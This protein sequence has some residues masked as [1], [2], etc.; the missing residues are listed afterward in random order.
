MKMIKT[1][2]ALVASVVMLNAGDYSGTLTNYTLLSNGTDYSTNGWYVSAI[3]IVNGSTNTETFVFYDNSTATN[4]LA[5]SY[6]TY[7]T[8]NYYVTNIVAITNAVT[9][10]N[11]YWTNI[12]A[13]VYTYPTAATYVDLPTVKSITVPA[14]TTWT[15]TS[16]RLMFSRGCVVRA[17]KSGS[18][19][20]NESLVNITYSRLR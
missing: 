5:A 16:L 15:E 9:T 20:T 14:A 12:T 19:A 2:L 1:F 4:R 8:S 11:T 3:Q 10:T 17:V 7:A 13:G 18:S 6:N